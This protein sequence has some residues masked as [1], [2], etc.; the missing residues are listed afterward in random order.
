MED[1]RR[2]DLGLVLLRSQALN[3]VYY[4]SGNPSTW[5]PVQRPGDN[6]WSMS[7]WARDLD[8]GKVK[9]I[10]Q[11]T[12]HDEWDF[13]GVNEMIL[14]DQSIGGQMRNA[15]DAFR[16]QRLRLHARSRHPANCWSRRSSIRS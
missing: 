10:Y 5:N 15:A 16:S 8:T 13:D 12:P 6:R 3:L 14:T 4:G 1:R 9:W 7:I 2:R 11:M